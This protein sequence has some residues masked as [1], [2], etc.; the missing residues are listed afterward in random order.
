MKVSFNELQSLSCKAFMG[1]GFSDG[2][3]TD[4]ITY[5]SFSFSYTI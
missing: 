1:M 5:G 4:A 3:A 2:Q